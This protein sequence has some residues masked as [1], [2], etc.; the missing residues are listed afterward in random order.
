MHTHTFILR[1]SRRERLQMGE[2]FDIRWDG[3]GNR[4]RGHSRPRTEEKTYLF[5]KLWYQEDV[6]YPPYPEKTKSEHP[7]EAANVSPNIK[8]L[9]IQEEERANR[10]C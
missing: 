6:N 8:S 3:R 4:P 10:F 5:H 2:S 9:H 1:S 7:H